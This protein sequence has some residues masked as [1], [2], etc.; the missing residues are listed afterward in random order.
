[1]NQHNL[2]NDVPEPSRAPESI[3]TRF[4]ARCA[5]FSQRWGRGLGWLAIGIIGALLIGY[6]EPWG[7][8]AYTARWLGSLFKAA[9]AAWGAYRISKGICSIDPSMA[10]TPQERGLLHLARAF[11]VGATIVAVL[12]AV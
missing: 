11:I 9:T 7:V 1:M 6:L 12:M 8:P 4:E 5:G 3:W 2:V 10:E